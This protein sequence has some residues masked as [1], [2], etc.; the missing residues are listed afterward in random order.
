M[1]VT[2][3]KNPG[4]N[5]LAQT[6]RREVAYLIS[7]LEIADAG[8]TPSPE[9]AAFLAHAASVAPGYTGPVLPA[10]QAVVTNNA[11]TPVKNRAG[12][13]VTGTH[14]I[15]VAGSVVTDVTLSPAIAPI[16]NAAANISV[17]NTGGAS[18]TTVGVAAVAAG[19]LTYVALPATVSGVINGATLPVKNSA[20]TTVPGTSTATI[21]AG[22]VTGVNLPATV[23][24]VVN[25]VKQS[26]WT[27]TGSGTFFTP[28]VTA[29]VCTGGV[30]S[31]S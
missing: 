25:A 8:G 27:V 3:L 13:A 29:G 19:V 26:G 10:T 22:A 30:L 16:A 9:L 6:V 20:G 28:T 15:H 2:T 7:Q 18:V 5:T 11:S 23:G 31:A 14:T 4:D 21:A 1:Q 17:L 24:V 12:T